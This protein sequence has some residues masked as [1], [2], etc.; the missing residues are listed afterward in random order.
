MHSIPRYADKLFSDIFLP[1]E[2][3][4]VRDEAR[5]FSERVLKPLSHELNTTT[6]R[7]DGFRHDVVRAIA[8]AGLYEIPFA[9]DVGGRGL[10]YPT[11][12]TLTVMEELGYYAPGVASALFDGQAI[13]CGQ[14]LNNAPKPIREMFLPKLIAGDVICC[15]A[16]SEPDTSTDLSAR[17]MQTTA[18]KIEGGYRVNGH[19]RW[20]TNSVA[21]DIVLLLCNTGNKLTMLLVDMHEKGITVSDPDLKMGNHAQLT[22]DISFEN[23]WVPEQH[24]IG[25]EGSGLRAALSA[26][27]IGL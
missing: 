24:R 14:T 16:T 6:E 2:C 4:L 20:I 15:F 5:E 10:K 22:S 7:R 25:L 13:L 12:A 18:T 8:D 17:S 1:D 21:G 3:K 26:L 11:L 27:T 9:K 23:V 19:K